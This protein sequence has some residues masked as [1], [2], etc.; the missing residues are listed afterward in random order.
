[1]KVHIPADVPTLPPPDLEYPEP[2]LD[3]ESGPAEQ[4]VTQTL[5]PPSDWSRAKALVFRIAFI[6]FVLYALPFPFGFIPG[7]DAVA[8]GYEKIWHVLVPWVAHHVLQVGYEIGLEETGSGDR[9]YNWVQ[10]FCFLALAI[11]GGLVWSALRRE[12]LRYDALYR[13][14]RL[15]V[16]LYLGA[17]MIGYG[18][19]KVIQSQF[20]PPNLTRL[21]QPYGDSSPMGLLW[22]F[23]GASYGYNLFTGAAEMIGGALLFIPPLATL[24]ALITIGA[25]SNV[26]VLNLTYDV[27]VKLS[28]FNLII[29]AFFIALPDAGRLANVLVFNRRTDPAVVRPFFKRRILNRSLLGLQLL[30]LVVFSGGALV[31]AWQ[32]TKF[33]DTVAVN[34]AIHGIWSVDEFMVDGQPR[35]LAMSDPTR[36]QRVILEYSNRLSI[37]FLDA[38]Q[39]RY[40]LAMDPATQTMNLTSREDPNWKAKFKYETP[41]PGFMIFKG[42]LEGHQFEAR[43]HRRDPATFRLTNR[44]FHWVNEYPFNR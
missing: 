16:R 9:A 5:E 13:W 39:Q 27:P 30:M 22:T 43:M 31:Q 19:A 18:A 37:Q 25:M 29:M 40:S 33:W 34:P 11:A 1:M 38:P 6:Y 44:G 41:K 24:G 17:T 15:Y 32:S 14:L 4:G 7:T 28:S 21:V 8:R 3:I 10:T 2:A 12:R 42:E 23:M 35:P 26:F 20:S 36:W